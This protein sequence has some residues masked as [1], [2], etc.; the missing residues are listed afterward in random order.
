MNIVVVRLGVTAVT[1]KRAAAIAGAIP[2]TVAAAVVAAASRRASG[3][4]TRSIRISV[5]AVLAA[6]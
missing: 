6:P 4:V 1:R 3:F 5:M 2:I